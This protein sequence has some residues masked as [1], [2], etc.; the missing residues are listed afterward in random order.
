M[1]KIQTYR[2]P[3]CGEMIVATATQCRFCGAGLDPAT[4]VGRAAH[5][6][7][8]NAAAGE[9]H[10][11]RTTAWGALGVLGAIWFVVTR[12]GAAASRSATNDVVAAL[13]G[14]W[15]LVAGV[16]VVV[17]VVQVVVLARWQRRYGRLEGSSPELLEAKQ[18]VRQ[19]YPALGIT[20]LGLLVYMGIIVSAVSSVR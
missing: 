18:S 2:C 16:A 14:L 8:V 15:V 7:Q 11:A 1:A 12:L 10:T 4:A 5:Q 17:M 19:A 3:T 6:A 13:A 9:A 20:V